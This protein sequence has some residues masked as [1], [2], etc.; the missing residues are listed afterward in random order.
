MTRD[1]RP[2][3]LLLA[4]GQLEIRACEYLMDRRHRPNNVDSKS[5][6]RLFSV[7]NHVVRRIADARIQEMFAWY[8]LGCALHCARY[9]EVDDLNFASAVALLSEALEVHPSALRRYARV[10]E[11]IRP[12]ELEF[13]SKLRGHDGLPLTWSHLDLLSEVRDKRERSARALETCAEGLTVRELASRIRRST[14]RE[15]PL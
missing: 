11:M 2:V 9:A 6:K 12:S 14:K 5:F 1:P 15:L 4:R 3:V 10:S 7:T 8:D 13:L